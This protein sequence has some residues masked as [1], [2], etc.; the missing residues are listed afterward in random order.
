MLYIG[1]LYLSLIWVGW[2]RVH[3]SVE[4]AV[5]LKNLLLLYKN[6]LYIG[7]SLYNMGRAV[8][9]TLLRRNCCCIQQPPPPL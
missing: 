5:V 2:H 7:I 9:G 1:I 8:A 6:M 3:R 4:T